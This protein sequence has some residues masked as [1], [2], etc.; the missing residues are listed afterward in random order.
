MDPLSIAAGVVQ[1]LH[2]SGSC[3]KSLRQLVH[4]VR[5]APDEILAV[6]NEVS[7]INL[8]LSDIEATNKALE[9]AGAHI[10][11]EYLKGLSTLL[12][13]ARTKL[14][15]LDGFVAELFLTQPDGQTK[16]Q[17]YN[18]VRKKSAVIALQK[19]LVDVKRKLG[20]LLNSATA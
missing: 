19:D 2:F 15:Q 4:T 5:H 6:S 8:I 9:A 20:L 16:F 14:G 12:P 13:L 18:W 1:F 11:H 7:D 3:S 10:N 17:R